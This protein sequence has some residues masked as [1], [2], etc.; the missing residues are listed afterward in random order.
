VTKSDI[1][2]LVYKIFRMDEEGLI[3]LREIAIT[4]IIAPKDKEYILRAIEL[5][6]NPVNDL[7]GMIVDG[8][9]TC[10]EAENII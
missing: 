9:L 4:S 2:E 6:L 1:K 3:S 10:E 5:R 7:E 8:E